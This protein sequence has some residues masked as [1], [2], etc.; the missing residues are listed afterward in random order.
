ML[1]NPD[2]SIDFHGFTGPF[3]QYTHARIKSILRKENIAAV[4]GF[5]QPLL[6]L[7]KELLVVMEQYPTIIEQAATEYN[8]SLIANYIFTVAKTFNS[9]VTEHKVLTADSAEKKQL[10]LR[11]CLMTANIIASGMSL[12]GIKVPERM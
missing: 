10:R 3:V 9:F 8:P 1:F 6:A 4:T 7:E 5:V 12:L 2:E 11:L